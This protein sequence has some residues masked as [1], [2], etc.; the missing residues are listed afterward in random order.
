MIDVLLRMPILEG[1]ALLVD[2]TERREVRLQLDLRQ[3]NLVVQYPGNDDLVKILGRLSAN[4]PEIVFL[5]NIVIL[6]PVG[7]LLCSRT[8]QLHVVNR[9]LGEREQSAAAHEEP[10]SDESGASST[11]LTLSPAYSLVEFKTEKAEANTLTVR[12]HRTAM[13]RTQFT[14]EGADYTFDFKD[15]HCTIRS[16]IPIWGSQRRLRLAISILLGTRAQ[17]FAVHESNTLRLSLAND[18]EYQRSHALFDHPNFG[19]PMLECLVR[20]LLALSDRDFNHWYKAAAFMIEGKSSFAELDIRITNLFVFLEMFDDAGSLSGN[21]VAQML[22]IPLSD[23]KLLC[24]VRNRLLHERHTLREAI[25]ASDAEQ[26][27]HNP[28]YALQAFAFADQ[29]PSV[30]LYLRLCER[31]NA[32]IARSIGWSGPHHTYSSTLAP[33]LPS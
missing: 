19:R 30:I 33:Y 31:I 1:H 6:G 25:D 8:G 24:G 23:A 32:F 15:P 10:P 14:V 27:A 22:E 3:R 2:G 20:F 11:R 9:I 28:R 17:L 4:E 29:S 12:C 21:A 16:S 18:V 5:E 7:S 13:P 26:R